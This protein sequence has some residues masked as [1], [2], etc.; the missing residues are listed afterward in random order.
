MM[1]AKFLLAITGSNNWEVY[2]AGIGRRAALLR[3]FVTF[4]CQHNTPNP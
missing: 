4:H 2:D 1:P 3:Y